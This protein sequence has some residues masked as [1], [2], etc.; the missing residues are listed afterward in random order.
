V[1]LKRPREDFEWAVEP[2][3]LRGL[4][5]VALRSPE[6]VTI[7]LPAKGLALVDPPISQAM[8]SDDLSDPRFYVLGV[9]SGTVGK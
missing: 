3:A 6:I 8:V 1:L 5:L 9:T 4:P 7:D 2:Q